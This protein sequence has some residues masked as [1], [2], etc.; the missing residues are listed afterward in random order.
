[1]VW[2]D[3]SVHWLRCRGIVFHDAGRDRKM[4]VTED[5]TERIH[6]QATLAQFFNLCPI[7]LTISGFDGRIRRTNPALS[8]TSGF[9]TEE[10]QQRRIIEL[11]HPDDH[12]ALDKEVRN[13]AATGKSSGLEVRIVKKD[14]SI[15]WMLVSMA[16]SPDDRS[17][18][19]ASY[20][21]TERKRAEEA[22][23]SS[24]ARFAGIVRITSA[25]V[26]GVLMA[27]VQHRNYTWNKI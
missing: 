12:E 20:D 14:G 23:R 6:A 15:S 17:I 1:V 13:I 9:T 24:E 3:G 21:I 11:F 2:P 16:V 22:A 5:I 26:C 7:P 18:Y 27:I 25:L 8:K 4:E 10:L 19:T